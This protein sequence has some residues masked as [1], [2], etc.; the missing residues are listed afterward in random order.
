[1]STKAELSD[2]SIIIRDET[3]SRKNSSYRVGS[4]F[5]DML[6]FLYDKVAGYFPLSGSNIADGVVTPE[7]LSQ[8]YVTDTQGKALQQDISTLQQSI[9]TLGEALQLS[10][11]TLAQ[12][13][14]NENASR[15][16]AE[17]VL[18][19]SIISL[20]QSLG[21]CS[22]EIETLKKQLDW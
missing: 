2:R 14:L 19:D 11:G 21:E 5:Y 8:N 22:R 10:I 12:D 17:G 3:S 13:I 15:L 4:L 16:E 20:V 6:N 1:M 18:L 9:G 7:K